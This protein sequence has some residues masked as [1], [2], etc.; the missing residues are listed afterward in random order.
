MKNPKKVLLVFGL[1]LV[2]VVG[3]QVLLSNA[4]SQDESQFL[5]DSMFIQAATELNDVAAENLVVTNRESEF[6]PMLG[7]SVHR[8]KLFN[9]Q[10]NRPMDVGVTLDDWGQAVDYEF[11][12]K[13]ERKAF[14]QKYG[15]LTPKLD[16]YLQNVSLSGNVPVAIWLNVD[17]KKIPKRSA[18]QDQVVSDL[19]T[20]IADTTEDLEAELNAREITIDYVSTIAPLIYAQIPAADLAVDSWLQQ[21]D[22]VQ[23]IYDAMNVN[24]DYL[25]YQTKSARIPA[26]WDQG[27]N[28]TGITVAIV[29]DSRI[30]FN[31]T[32]LPNNAGTRVPGDSN[33]DDHA[34]GTGGMV[35]SSN[36]TYRGASY[37]ASLR[38]S[39]GTTYSDANMAAAIDDAANYAHIQ[40]N[41]W[42]PTCGDGTLNVHARHADWVSR[43]TARTVVGSAGNNGGTYSCAYV[44]GVAAGFNVI[45]VGSYDNHHTGLWSDDTMSS[46]S[47][48]RDP[49]GP[50]ASYAHYKPEVAGPGQDS[51]IS[52]GIASTVMVQ[53]S[54]YCGLARIGAGTSYSSP[55]VSGLAALLMDRNYE[56]RYWP[57]VIK[58]AIMQGAINNIE[59]ASRFSDYDGAGGISGKKTHKTVKRG[60]LSFGVL[61]DATWARGGDI[62]IPLST[63]TSPGRKYR[64][65]LCWASNP[66]SDPYTIDPLNWDV[67]LYLYI[68]GI[69][70]ASSSSIPNSFEIIEYTPTGGDF[71]MN[72]VYISIHQYSGGGTTYYGVAWGKYD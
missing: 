21:R 18:N 63:I 26:V 35:G 6:L 72:E 16:S 13:E 46:F 4:R 2:L 64:I 11:L 28:G 69:F 15:K 38:S 9:T 41:S 39:N 52:G 49:T 70:R 12:K 66:S 50:G 56:L 58:A 10:K 42:G 57:E 53:P 65:V 61:N 45:G 47:S 54:S 17:E 19:Q 36:T 71:P 7:Y 67:D 40:N 3:L 1:S 25:Y 22:D 20:F 8:A 44:A 31:N 34:T 68:N 62:Y 48:Y 30:D 51:G 32:C 55:I 59:G 5:P 37:A 60:D 43:N 23:R 29:E 33:V 14:T 27:I 24:E